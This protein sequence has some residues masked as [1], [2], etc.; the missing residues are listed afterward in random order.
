MQQCSFRPRSSRRIN[1]RSLHDWHHC[2]PSEHFL[3]ARDLRLPTPYFQAN[4][5][6]V[7]HEVDTFTVLR[8]H[9]PSTLL[10]AG[11]LLPL[12]RSRQPAV[13]AENLGRFHVTTT[14]RCSLH[15]T[16][17]QHCM[18]ELTICYA[19]VEPTSGDG[20]KRGC[21]SRSVSALLQ[22]N[23]TRTSFARSLFSHHVQGLFRD[24]CR[25]THHLR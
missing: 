14:S 6:I 5:T 16:E 2:F 7:D 22:W 24:T 11:H 23:I 1:T 10:S 12:Q 3:K 4:W 9:D 25:G 21:D 20:P 13:Q 19:I 15:A 18:T 17:V 8:H